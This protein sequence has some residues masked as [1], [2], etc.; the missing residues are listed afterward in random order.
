MRGEKPQATGDQVEAMIRLLHW[1]Q[2]PVHIDTL[3][4]QSVA[5]LTHT[6]RENVERAQAASFE[7]HEL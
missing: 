5:A 7:R 1:T 3:L 4:D 2:D 6:M